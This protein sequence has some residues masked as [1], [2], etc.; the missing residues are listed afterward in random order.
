MITRY[1]A[2]EAPRPGI[3]LTLSLLALALMFADTRLG[4][5]CMPI[6]FAA[7][8]VLYWLLYHRKHSGNQTLPPQ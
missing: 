1:R 5:M 2:P 8:A 3:A 4:L 6:W 7:C